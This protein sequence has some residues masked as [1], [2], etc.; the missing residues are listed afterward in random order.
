MLH[1][2]IDEAGYGPLLGPLVIAVSAW[3][4]EGL[5]PED[6]PGT[7]LGA[8]LA[9]FVVPAR[10]RRGADAPVASAQMAD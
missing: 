5:R 6:D 1:L 8:R 2:G 3:R 4:V 7:V 10:G 9:P